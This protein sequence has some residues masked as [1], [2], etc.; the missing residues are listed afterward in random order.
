MT[1]S[2]SRH[3]FHWTSWRELLLLHASGTCGLCL[4]PWG[5]WNEESGDP[6][7]PL[8]IYCLS[9]TGVSNPPCVHI[10]TT[11]QHVTGSSLQNTRTLWV[12]FYKLWK[13]GF[14]FTFPKIKQWTFSVFFPCISLLYIN[15][16]VNI[17][18]W[19]LHS[20]KHTASLKHLGLVP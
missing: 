7:V 6:E 5:N 13:T 1:T 19:E 14:I 20:T 18:T 12:K 9:T 3:T 11:W 2:S 15:T 17:H 16:V 10:Q 8:S 4:L